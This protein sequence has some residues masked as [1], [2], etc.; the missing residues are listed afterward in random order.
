MLEQRQRN[1][2]CDNYCEQD[3]CCRY[4]EVVLDFLS[5]QQRLPGA[6]EAV[7]AVGFKPIT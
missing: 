2:G 1:F 5:W 6:I 7:T 3:N 4:N